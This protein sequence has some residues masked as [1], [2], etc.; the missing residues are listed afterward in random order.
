MYQATTTE[1]RQQADLLCARLRIA[2]TQNDF[3]LL[4]GDEQAN[5]NLAAV[6]NWIGRQDGMRGLSRL[7]VQAQLHDSL[8]Q[9]L[10]V[11]FDD[12]FL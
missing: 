4:I 1:I 12:L 9:H 8:A 6:C 10:I 3:V 2:P 7:I 11:R 5:S